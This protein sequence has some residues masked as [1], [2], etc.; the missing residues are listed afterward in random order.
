[1]VT[2]NGTLPPIVLF[3]TSAAVVCVGSLLYVSQLT[4]VQY[5]GPWMITSAIF[6]LAV[7]LYC[8]SRHLGQHFNLQAIRHH[9]VSNRNDKS[10]EKW[11][12]IYG[13]II[14]NLPLNKL[15]L[16]ETHDAGTFRM[17]S[18]VVEPWATTQ[19]ATLQEQLQGGVR[20]LDLRVGCDGPQNY[21]LVHGKWRTTTT[22]DAALV[23][24]CDFVDCNTHELV[25]LDF[26]RFVELESSFDWKE[27]QHLVMTTLGQRLY[28]YT[29]VLPTLSQIWETDGRIIVAWNST[30]GMHPSFFPGVQQ[31]WYPAVTTVEELR[32]AIDNDLNDDAA[33]SGLWTVGA[34]IPAAPLR[35]VPRIPQLLT[36]FLPGQLWTERVNIIQADFVVEI[37]LV[38]NAIAQCVLNAME[39]YIS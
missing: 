37:D 39:N 31:G 7:F 13:A 5:V 36:W 29:G 28:S 21:V 24:V 18:A 34:V 26:H 23:T 16:V 3:R 32:V 22:L 8:K 20:V 17:K 19:H 30:T 10:L 15:C 27:L 11:M 6:V 1:M 33:K 25:I 35:R 4:Y 9:L 14:Q 2:V 38:P 12:E